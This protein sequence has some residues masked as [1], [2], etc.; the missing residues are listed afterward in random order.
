MK[1]AQVILVD[2]FTIEWDGSTEVCGDG[3][4]TVKHKDASKRNWHYTCY[5]PHALEQLSSLIIGE[6]ETVEDKKF[7]IKMKMAELLP[8]L[9]YDWQQKWNPDYELKTWKK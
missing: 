4:Y 5:F 2:G 9:P 7:L 3:L 6:C 1:F 8:K